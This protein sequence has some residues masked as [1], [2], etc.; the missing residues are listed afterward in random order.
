MNEQI[1]KIL[2]KKKSV[3][4][5]FNRIMKASA[6]HRIMRDLISSG[7]DHRFLPNMD[8][9]KIVSPKLVELRENYFLDIA[10]QTYEHIT[11]FVVPF[12]WK[13]QTK[14]DVYFTQA[15]AVIAIDSKLENFC[16]PNPETLD[17][18]DVSEYVLENVEEQNT[19]I[20]YFTGSTYAERLQPDESTNHETIDGSV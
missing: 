11:L 13:K 15:G 6:Q 7:V 2:L 14:K 17:L 12:W 16:L 1:N 18:F 8:R 19:G 10:T 20:A 4:T 3:V 5:R 9:M